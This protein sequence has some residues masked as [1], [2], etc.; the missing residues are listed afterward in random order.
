MRESAISGKTAT[1]NQLRN[2]DRICTGFGNRAK[3]ILEPHLNRT[4]G[5]VNSHGLGQWGESQPVH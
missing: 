1:T 2:N 4:T 3:F 5:I